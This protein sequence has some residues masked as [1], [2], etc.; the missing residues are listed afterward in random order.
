VRTFDQPTI[1][2]RTKQPNNYNKNQQ[3]GELQEPSKRAVL[4]AIEA[5]DALVEQSKDGEGLA[6]GEGATR[7]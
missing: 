5:Q 7:V 1:K 6:D 2:Q 4:R 3:P